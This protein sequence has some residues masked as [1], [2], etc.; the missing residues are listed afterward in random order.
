MEQA[1]EEGRGN[2]STDERPPSSMPPTI[3]WPG[4]KLIDLNIA[5]IVN[6]ILCH[7]DFN[8][9]VR[10]REGMRLETMPTCICYNV[11][12]VNLLVPVP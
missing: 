2:N 12:K 9:K 1:S 7:I 10:P 5:G 11:V 3:N 4:A 6:T 8:E